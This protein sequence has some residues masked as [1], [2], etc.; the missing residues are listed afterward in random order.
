MSDARRRRRA[1]QAQEHRGAA[2]HGGRV[3]PASGALPMAKGDVRTSTELLEFKTTGKLQLTI[4]L[5]DLEKIRGE[6]LIEGR[7]ALFG[8]ALGGRDY[9][10]IEA[11]EYIGLV[12]DSHG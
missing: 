12:E 9:I 2:L 10:V 11:E 3:R 4:K 6:A 1:S 8:F 7:R 5:R